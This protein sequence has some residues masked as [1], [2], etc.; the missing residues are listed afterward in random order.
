MRNFGIRMPHQ[1]RF[2]ADKVPVPRVGTAGTH[3]YQHLLITDGRRIDLAELQDVTGGAIPVLDDRLHHVSLPGPGLAAQ[4][5]C[6]RRS[7]SKAAASSVTAA[8]TR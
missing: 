7:D 8:T 6:H 2:A 4:V 5:Q 3:P 1:Y